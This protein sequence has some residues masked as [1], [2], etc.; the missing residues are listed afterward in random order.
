MPYADR[1]DRNPPRVLGTCEWFVGHKLFRD[2]LQGS[3]GKPLWVSADPGCGKSVLA[4]YLVEDVIQTTET[5]TTCY[6]FFK[7]DFKEQKSAASAISC[8]LHQI[9][10][11]QPQLLS[12]VRAR[13]E[14]DG[15]TLI[16]S[17]RDLWGLLLDVAED[18]DTG[19]IVCVLD[20]LDECGFE[21]SEKLARALLEQ[22]R[23]RRAPNLKF[24]LTSRPFGSIRRSFQPPDIAELAVVHLSGESQAESEEISREIDI[25]IRARVRSISARLYLQED[26]QDRLLCGLLSVPHRTYLWVYLTLDLLESDVNINKD[27]IEM[28]ISNLPMSVD[29]AYERILS[30]SRD[31]KEAKRALHIIVIAETPLTLREMNFAMALRPAHKYYQHVKLKSDEWFQERLRDICGLFVTVVDSKVYL[32]HQ[33]AREFLVRV[34]PVE[35]QLSKALKLED[36]EPSLKWK[37][38]LDPP[39]SHRILGEICLWHLRFLELDLQNGTGL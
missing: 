11:Q 5:R 12:A 15:E 4:R 8:L 17:F 6:F 9:F 25:F 16:T 27:K 34:D 19:E 31:A 3:E 18:Q 24:L 39:E 33:T 30:T 38:S 32:L 2:W 1:K 36:D 13:L 20:A 37:Y 21:D 14:A 28:A 22:R 26:K 10:S 35:E 7:D 29:H 23:R